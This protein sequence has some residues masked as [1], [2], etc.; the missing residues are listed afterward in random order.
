M[1]AKRLL[2]SVGECIVEKPLYLDVFLSTLL[3]QLAIAYFYLR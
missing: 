3:V 1:L 2:D